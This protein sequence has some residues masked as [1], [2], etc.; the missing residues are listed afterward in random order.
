MDETL[1]GKRLAVVLVQFGIGDA[2]DPIPFVY[3]QLQV[4]SHL[5]PRRHSEQLYDVPEFLL[6]VCV[7]LI[8]YL[9][10]I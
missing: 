6:L 2:Q 5:Q 10:H 8:D 9:R 4:S 3:K 1:I 7:V